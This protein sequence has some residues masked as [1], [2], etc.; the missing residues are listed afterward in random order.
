METRRRQLQIYHDQ[1]GKEPFVEWVSRLS[2]QH[3]ARIFA[4]LD[5]VETG[6]FGD[7]KHVGAGVFELRFHFGA[8]YR[9]YF[10]E[11]GAKIILLLCG[12]KK[13]S[14]K[15]DIQHAKEYWE[16]YKRGQGA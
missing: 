3:R 4:R 14:Q 8:G 12:G 7:C 13:S 6:N 1:Q 2:R 11:I 10:G 15:K 9:V 5:R 16:E